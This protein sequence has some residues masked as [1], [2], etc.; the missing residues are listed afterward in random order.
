MSMSV[1]E[2]HV[3]SHASRWTNNDGL[4]F[5]DG[6]FDRK[7]IRNAPV[8]AWA[9][10]EGLLVLHGCNTALSRGTGWSPAAEFAS[11]QRVRTVGQTGTS[12]MSGREE[13]YDEIA[14][15]TPRVYLWAYRR[16]RYGPAW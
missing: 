7:D 2:G 3:F 6:T 10:Q 1:V 16:G 15:T 9:K 8:L 13:Q 5:E 11:R 4:E 14:A 12:Y